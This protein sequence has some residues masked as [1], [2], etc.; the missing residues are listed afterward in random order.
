MNPD[1]KTSELRLRAAI[2]SAPSGLL[3]I[4]SEGRIV[5]VNREVERMFGYPRE[6]LLGRPVESIVPERFREHHP[7][8]RGAFT[9]RPSVRQMGVGRELF[10]RRKDG[11]EVPIEIGLTPLVTDE[12]LFVLSSIVDITARRKA[13][14]R[15]RVAVESAPSGMVMVDAEG[16]IVLVN[17]EVERLFGYTREEL[18]GRS[19]ETLVPTRFRGG[20]PGF[21]A[22]F[23]QDPQARMMGAGRELYGLRKDGV[24]VPVEIGLN[25]IDTDDGLFVLGSIVDI[26][27]R[28]AARR[29]RAQ[30]E[31]QLRQS[32]KMEAVGTLAGGIAHDF[33]NILR[34]I[35]GYAELAMAQVQDERVRG[36]LNEVIRAAA[37]GKEL[38]SAILRFSRREELS[39]RPTDL[40]QVV[41]DTLR[42]LRPTLPTTI[43][44]RPAIDSGLARALADGTAVQQVLMNLATN[45]AHAMRNGGRLEIGVE[46]FYGRDSW[47]KT[48]PGMR[49][50]PYILIRVQDFGEGMPREVLERA[51]EPFFTTKG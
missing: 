44:V 20:H 47:V 19:V 23:H 16:K 14:A 40:G 2:D 9:E 48:H 7:A 39:R 28:I 4:D 22:G 25:P 43:E 46:S 3:M 51:F 5:L 18:L 15:F 6:E 31:D 41:N 27:A 50:G 11:S 36:D 35:M 13:E 42:L 38:V 26:S 33:N 45:A 32:Q 34:G 29:E 12:G 21:R 24:E 49:E 1:S 10:G 8:Y 30:L 17:R 37:R